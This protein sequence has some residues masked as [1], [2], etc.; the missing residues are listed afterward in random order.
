MFLLNEL[1]KAR[2]AIDAI[3]EKIAELFVS[4]M[5]AVESVIAYKKA[6]DLKIFDQGREKEVI[7]KNMALVKEVIYKPYYEK[8]LVAMMTISKDYQAKLNE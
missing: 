2:I 6:N 5:K 8:F 1:E 3:D 7:E 4:R